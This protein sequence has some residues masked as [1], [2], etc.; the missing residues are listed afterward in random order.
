MFYYKHYY[1]MEQPNQSFVIWSL[2]NGSDYVKHQTTGINIK[3]IYNM[4]S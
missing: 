2:Y 4:L 3:T 1:N